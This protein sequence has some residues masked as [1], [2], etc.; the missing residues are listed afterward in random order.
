VGAYIGVIS[1]AMSRFGFSNHVVHSFEAD[2]LNFDHLKQ[3]VAGGSSPGISIHNI[4]VADLSGTAEFTRNIDHGTNH[5][6][7]AAEAGDSPVVVYEVPVTSLDDFV[8]ANGIDTIDVL[9]IDVEGADLNVLRGAEGLLGN[10]RIK[11][12]IVE[13]P[14]TV[15]QRSEMIDLLSAH[16]YSTAYIV[17]NTTKLAEPTETTYSGSERAPLN[18]ISVRPDLADPMGVA[19]TK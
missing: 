17:R 5:L 14:M 18:M 12:L 4:A 1:L 3:N 7:S 11:V 19:F 9:K 6:G 2:D 8:E 16:G 10:E 15:E 13:I